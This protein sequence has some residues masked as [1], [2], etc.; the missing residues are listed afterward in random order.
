MACGDYTPG[1]VS[2]W[3]SEI[4]CELESG[5]MYVGWDLAVAQKLAE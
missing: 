3:V 4:N 2:D 1:D 5:Q